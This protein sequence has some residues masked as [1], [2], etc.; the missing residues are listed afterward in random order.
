MDRG[1]RTG[2]TGAV[3]LADLHLCEGVGLRMAGPCVSDR[4]FPRLVRGFDKGY[5][6]AS[7]VHSIVWQYINA[8]G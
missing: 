6:V 8:N 3:S 7:I 1:P 5:F 4:R 2:V